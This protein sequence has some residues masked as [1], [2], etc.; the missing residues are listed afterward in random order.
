MYWAPA[1]DSGV[2]VGNDLPAPPAGRTYQL[3]LVTGEARISAGTFTPSA[4]GTVLVR[5]TYALPRDALRA[6][7][8]TVEAEG[9]APQPTGEMVLVS[10]AE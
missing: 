6:V 2:F 8:V 7:A 3:W 4:D 9:G 1:T 10:A 5:A